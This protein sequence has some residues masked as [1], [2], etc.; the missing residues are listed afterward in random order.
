MNVMECHV[1][2]VFSC[3]HVLI[4]EIV[5]PTDMIE[6]IQHL[7]VWTAV[8]T[9]MY[10]HCTK[11]FV[12]HITSVQRQYSKTVHKET[13]MYPAQKST[14]YVFLLHPTKT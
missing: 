8:I 9:N 13:V 4:L 11:G 3:Q 7:K 2:L 5:T 12:H 6:Q 10:R 14:I 1:I